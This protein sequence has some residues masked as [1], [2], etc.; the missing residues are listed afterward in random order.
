M[1]GTRAIQRSPLST[2]P[3][4][5]GRPST[6]QTDVLSQLFQRLLSDQNAPPAHLIERAPMVAPPRVPAVPPRVTTLPP[7]RTCVMLSHHDTALLV[8]ALGFT[9]RH[10]AGSMTALTA[11]ELQLVRQ[12]TALLHRS[13]PRVARTAIR[14]RA[15]R[16]AADAPMPV[17]CLGV[18]ARGRGPPR[19]QQH[20]PP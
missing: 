2:A 20:H 6:P 10:C 18:T 15:V 17:D 5:A 7:R 1:T 19:G 16:M 14:E 4:G 8:L 11:Q 9:L 12:L 13:L 3:A